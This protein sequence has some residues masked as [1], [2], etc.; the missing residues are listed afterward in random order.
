ML[1]EVLLK[2][3]HLVVED[4]HLVEAEA[5]ASVVEVSP[6]EDLVRNSFIFKING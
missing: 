3:I 5:E 2:A 6:A 4:S 1:P